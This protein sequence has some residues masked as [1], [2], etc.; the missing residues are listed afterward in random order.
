[1]R[2]FVDK[3]NSIFD[4]VQNKQPHN[5]RAK[6]LLYELG[7][8]V[9]QFSSELAP[10]GI[11]ISKV[12]ILSIDE[13]K[14]YT[15]AGNGALEHLFSNDSKFSSTLIK[16]LSDIS[17]NPMEY[18]NKTVITYP[19]IAAK[20]TLNPYISSIYCGLLYNNYC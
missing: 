9:R 19:N 13:N 3:Y 18:L 8:T 16:K 17:L 14:M 5:H 11:T 12:G 20:K 7:S 15:A 10:C 4:F 2:T 1:M 6:K